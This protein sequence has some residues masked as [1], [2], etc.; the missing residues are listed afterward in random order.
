MHPVVATF[1][2]QQSAQEVLKYLRR[3]RSA[4]TRDVLVVDDEGRLAGV[5]DIHDLALAFGKTPLGQLMRPAK[6]MAT[7]VS[8]R[9]EIAEIL[10]RQKITE[11][12]VVDTHER[13]VGVVRYG[14]LISAVLDETSADIQT[15]VGVRS[16]ER[17]LSSISFK[18]RK[19]LPWLQI[20]L[21][22]AFLASA[23]VGL[24]V[25]TIALISMLAVRGPSGA[26]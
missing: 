22:T 24:F 17:A 10:E 3:F 19:R 25:H 9:E 16:D 23:V 5:V 1:R 26:G 8:S 6:T 2:A 11:L 12:P 15:M 18:V 21:A 20:N 4:A 13:V 7:V 14:G